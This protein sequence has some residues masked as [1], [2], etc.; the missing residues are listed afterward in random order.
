MNNPKKFTTKG[1]KEI[2]S[3]GSE[4]LIIVVVKV[5]S[6]NGSCMMWLQLISL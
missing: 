1:M 4:T 2:P 5:M 3:N 6:L